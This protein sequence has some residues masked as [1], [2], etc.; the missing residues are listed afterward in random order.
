MW[1]MFWEFLSIW[2]KCNLHMLTILIWLAKW[3]LLYILKIHS[4]LHKILSLLF[5]HIPF[6][7]A[8][9]DGKELVSISLL[10]PISS[11]TQTQGSKS[12]LVIYCFWLWAVR[13]GNYMW[14]VKVYVM[15][16]RQLFISSWH[17]QLWKLAIH[18]VLPVMDLFN[19][20]V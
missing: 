4:K 16:L 12:K 17:L 15:E 11:T 1:F 2:T 9:R 19:Q 5:I 20:T 7:M 6:S 8:S 14:L 10:C 18:L 13:S 3:E